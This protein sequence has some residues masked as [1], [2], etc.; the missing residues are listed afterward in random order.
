MTRAEPIISMNPAPIYHTIIIGGGPAGLSAALLLGRCLRDVLILDEGLPRNRMSKAMHGFLGHDGICPMTFLTRSREQLDPY[1]T[2]KIHKTRVTDLKKGEMGFEV[3]SGC[4]SFTSRTVL[5]AT[6]VR[7]NWPDLP[8]SEPF[9]GKSLH[10][11]PYCDA[12]EHRGQRFGVYG[13]DRKA[14]ELAVELRLWSES[15]TLFPGGDSPVEAELKACLARNGIAIQHGKI[16]TLVGEEG[17]LRAIEVDHLPHPC[18]ALF[19]SP[20]QTHS[21]E[22]AVGPGC[23]IDPRDSSVHCTEDGGTGVEG[24]FVAGNVTDGIQMAVIAA[25]E[26]TKAAVCINNFLMEQDGRFGGG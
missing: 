12:W 4:G 20:G 21:S 6:G 25:A 26:G 8:G 2:V 22:L 11:C 1:R 24:L 19:F 15:V 7:D 5:L 13:A 16:T 14:V 18:E 23:R 10:H 9:R 17:I 3:S